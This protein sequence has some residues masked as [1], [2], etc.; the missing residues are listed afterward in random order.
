MTG[1]RVGVAV[2]GLGHMGSLHARMLAASARAELVVCCD[3]DPAKAVECPAGARFT[4]HLDDALLDPDIQA[5]VVATPDDRHREPVVAALSRGLAVLCEKPIATSLE[6]ADAM[7]AEADVSGALLAIGHVLRFDPRFAAVKAAQEAGRLG[8]PVHLV[9][10]NNSAASEADRL[11]RRTNLPLYVG[12][13]AVDIMRWLAGTV[14]RVHAEGAAVRVPGRVDSVAAILR[15]EKG[16][17]GLIELSWGLPY[18]AGVP[19]GEHRLSYVGT[20]SCAFVSIHHHGVWMLGAD[21][22]AP[23]TQTFEFPDAYFRPEVHGVQSGSFAI[24]LESFLSAVRDGGDP[25]VGARDA[26]AAVEVA[27]AM[28]ESLTSGRTVPLEPPHGNGA[29]T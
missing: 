5:V 13:H 8:D 17:L 27:L 12:V 1:D 11:S 9:V 6:D 26:R 18:S 23:G 29:G 22:A 10:R 14:T 4:S 25:V 19:T 2:V 15:F 7:I 16:A 20:R 24:Q 28:E 3:V 21:E